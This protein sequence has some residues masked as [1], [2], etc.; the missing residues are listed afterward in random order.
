M[1]IFK[2]FSNGWQLAKS[3]L[4]IIQEN[5]DL[6]VFPVFSSISLIL[7]LSTFLG[8]GY[9]LIGDQLEEIFANEEQSN[10]VGYL[11]IFIYY[12]INFFIVTFFNAGL[13][14]CAMKILN[15]E[16]TSI[17]DGLAFAWS[18]IDK[19]LSW[20]VLSAT[21]GLLLNILQQQ[22]KIG[23]I[24]AGL[25]GLAWSILTFFVV[26]ILIYEDM[27]VIDSVKASGKIIKEKWGESLAGNFSLGLMYLLGLMFAVLIGFGFATI[28]PI[29]GGVVVVL[30][31]LLLAT[32]LSAAKT[33]FVAAVYNHVNG[34]PTGS[35]DDNVL[36]DIFMHKSK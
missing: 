17:N 19:I 16:E 28:H 11:M 26:P 30:L 35:F 10:M 32:I 22:G 6:L 36:D 1:G 24:I 20:S 12:L 9:L 29:V 25:L 5:K 34:M 4:S 27:G 33:V 8:G 14:H 31:I 2:K 13:I 21:I 15:G 3:S 23:E 7:I 18:K